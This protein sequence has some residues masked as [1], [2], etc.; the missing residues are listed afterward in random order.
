MKTK[1]QSIAI[2]LTVAIPPGI[3]PASTFVSGNVSGTW[4]KA[5]S[6]YVLQ[7]NCT[8]PSDQCL[9]IQP[10][11]TV[12]IG[13][14][15]ILDVEGCISAVGTAAERIVIRGASPSLYWDRIYINYTAAP[16]SSFVNCIISD[17]TNAVYLFINSEWLG[18]V[19][20]SATI[21]DCRFTNCVVSCVTG[22]SHGWA[23]W[24]GPSSYG[25][26]DPTLAPSI[27]DCVFSASGGGCVFV[28]EGSA[29][30]YGMGTG[31]GR[32]KVNPLIANCIFNSIF[33][34]ALSFGVGSY[35]NT[36]TPKTHN[37][38]FVGCTFAIRRDAAWFNDEVSFNGFFNNMTNFVGY[39]P[40]VHGTICC[41][42]NNGTSCDLLNNIFENPLFAETV[43]YTLA[44]N[45]P[46]IDA[47]NPDGAYLD[48]MFPPSQGTTVNDIGLYGGPH[49]GDWLT[50]AYNGTT[51]FMLTARQ[52]VGVTIN[53][54]AA[55][56][57]R[58]DYTPMFENSNIWTQ[59]TNVNLLST[60]WTYI[61]FDS[62][63][64]DQRYYRAVLLP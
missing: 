6:P 14:G 37:N 25:T 35:P 33:G 63:A 53:P 49:A 8:V 4:D 50:K 58:L 15:L 38:L 29:A 17:A 61:D 30:S 60:P 34:S 44:T 21:F 23:G 46:C 18:S 54:S 9:T 36:S 31:Y 64:I 27:Q 10:G 3:C 52:Y 28:A 24:H 12:I 2:G 47:G 42:N 59:I 7:G 5:G 45:S 22:V 20:R 13:Q 62:Q 40:G 19:T 26:S 57:Y 56:H 11:V 55:G 41:V 51:N 43:N 1:L 16:D 32:G 39:P 48:T